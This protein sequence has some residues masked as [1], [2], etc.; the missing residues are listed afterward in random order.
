MNTIISL[1]SIEDLEES[2]YCEGVKD[3]EEKIFLKF[4]SH[5]NYTILVSIEAGLRSAVLPKSFWRVIK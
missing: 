2:T 3:Y 4:I 5:P 1:S